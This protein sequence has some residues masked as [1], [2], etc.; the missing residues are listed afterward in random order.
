[1]PE[2]GLRPDGFWAASVDLTTEETH[3][4]ARSK[5]NQLRFMEEF[6]KRNADFVSSMATKK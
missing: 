3:F 4:F 1:M 5:E 2:S 6:I